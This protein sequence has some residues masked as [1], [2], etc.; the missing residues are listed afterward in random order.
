[1]ESNQGTNNLV[2]GYSGNLHFSRLQ[3][4][5]KTIQQL[6]HIRVQLKVSEMVVHLHYISHNSGKG[7]EILEGKKIPRA[8]ES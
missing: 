5:F 2:K 6:H 4:R 8:E 7:Q 3:P 1:M